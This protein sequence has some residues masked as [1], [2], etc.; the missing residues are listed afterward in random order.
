MS[1]R[2]EEKLQRLE[3]K[4]IATLLKQ[5]DTAQLMELAKETQQLERQLGLAGPLDDDELH[6]WILSR[7]GLDIPRVAVCEGHQ[8]PFQFIADA[9]FERVTSAVVMASRGGSK[10]LGV[11]ILHLLNSKYKQN[12]SS[13]S[14]GAIESQAFRAYEHLRRLLKLEGRCDTAEH[15]ADIDQSLMRETR[16]KNGSKVEIAASSMNAVNGP[17]PNKLHVDEVELMDRT[18]FFETRNM[19][20]S[21][22]GICA[23]DWI[24]STRKGSYGLMQ[25][26]IDSIEDAESKEMDPPF[27]LYT[28]CVF[29][30]A[31]NV[32][33]CAYAN[34]ELSSDEGC[35]CDRVIKGNWEDG[36]TRSLKDTCRG[37]LA[38]AN[39]WIPFEDVKKL[40]RSMPR[41]VWEAQ[42]ECSKPSAEGMV[43]PGFDRHVHGIRWWDPDPM[44]GSVYMSVDWGGTAPHAVNWYQVLR[45]DTEA[46]AFGDVRGQPS[47]LLP[48]GSR[49]CFDEIYIAEIGNIALANLI[50]KR[51]SLWGS[52][53][54]GWRVHKRFSDPQGKAA[55]LDFARH[56][57]PLPTSWYV[58]RDVKEHV[59]AVREM[60]DEGLF[61]LDLDRCPMMADEIESWHYPSKK[62]GLIDDPEIPIEDGIH[63]VANLRYFTANYRAIEQQQRR[64]AGKGRARADSKRH[65]THALPA[66]VGAGHDALPPGEEWRANFG[67]GTVL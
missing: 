63:A 52:R 7:L 13:M 24:T 16:W 56:N 10:T 59:K 2:E 57:P 4:D 60:F 30:C 29:D 51:E 65:I 41:S 23:Q 44:L 35:G 26:L 28:W 43:V 47:K 37:R 64:G 11:A 20:I 38:H 49:V 6:A 27:K 1:L 5:L 55:R 58:T 9:Y 25:E 18:I 3:E 15:H 46:H 61:F 53:H 42:Q 21:S 17:H 33:N 19:S 48:A 66:F 14:L 50:V 54:T 67:A 32:P 45:E 22:G 12:C 36:R 40:F 31:M 34:P 39:G 8:A 62:M